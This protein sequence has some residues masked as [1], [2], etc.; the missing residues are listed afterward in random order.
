MSSQSLG[1]SDRLIT[2]MSRG[3]GKLR[4]VARGAQKAASKLAGLIQPLNRVGLIL[5][6]GRTLDGIKGGKQLEDFHKLRS[7]WSTMCYASCFAELTSRIS[8]EGEPDEPLYLLLVTSL[9][10]L[11]TDL[12]PHLV[13][14]FFF[15]RALKVAGFL[16]QLNYCVYCGEEP[17]GS[18][19][20]DYSRG[21]ILCSACDGQPEGTA[22]HLPANLLQLFCLLRDV[23]PQQLDKLPEHNE[24]LWINL[25]DQVLTFSEYHFDEQLKSRRFLDILF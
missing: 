4:V 14:T 1:E 6:K 3:R 12:N 22:D 25:R 8:Q 9:R 16:P 11:N 24:Q 13:G 15:V 7:E 20:L 23:H 10:A 18:V 21:G 19:V 2:L 17:Q 5:W